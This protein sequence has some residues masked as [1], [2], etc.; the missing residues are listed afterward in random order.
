M[1]QLPD[2]V[3]HL[4]ILTNANVHT[5]KHKMALNIESEIDSLCRSLSRDHFQSQE[6]HQAQKTFKEYIP[7]LVHQSHVEHDAD[8]ECVAARM[9][10]LL[11]K[12]HAEDTSSLLDDL[13]ENGIELLAQMIEMKD[14]VN[15]V[16]LLKDKKFDLSQLPAEKG[17]RLLDLAMVHFKNDATVFDLLLLKGADP[18]ASDYGNRSPLEEIVKNRDEVLFRLCLKRK[19][20][21]FKKP[22]TLNI[23]I[24]KPYLPFFKEVLGKMK[25][26]TKK[27]VFADVMIEWESVWKSVLANYDIPFFKELLQ[28]GVPLMNT[29]HYGGDTIFLQ[30]V[31]DTQYLPFLKLGLKQMCPFKTGESIAFPKEGGKSYLR[32]ALDQYNVPAFQLLLDYGVDPMRLPLFDRNA[33]FFEIVHTGNPELMLLLFKKCPGIVFEKILQQIPASNEKDI[34]LIWLS[35]Y[36]S[37]EAA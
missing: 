14:Q 28:Q 37:Q 30:I 9:A 1:A 34:A 33:L 2:I 24:Q 25:E 26:S 6:A 11:S 20:K 23:L 3:R 27:K 31:R 15:L 10:L 16:L 19:W 4:H 18:F 8:L 5:D 7:L 35:P 17:A 36:L 13:G 21:H 29:K 12:S 32:E 22:E